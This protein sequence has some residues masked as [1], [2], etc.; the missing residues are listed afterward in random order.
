MHGALPTAKLQRSSNGSLHEGPQCMSDVRFMRRAI[1]VAASSSVP[2]LPVRPLTCSFVSAHHN[3]T[4][5]KG[6][7]RADTAR[8]ANSVEARSS[9]RLEATRD[10]FLQRLSGFEIDRYSFS[11]GRP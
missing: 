4:V 7:I 2:T 5:G 9:S 11:L 1:G 6:D 10:V 8:N 3:A